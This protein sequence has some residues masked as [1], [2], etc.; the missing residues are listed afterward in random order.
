MPTP[1]QSELIGDHPSAPS[2]FAKWLKSNDLPVTATKSHRSLTPL[3]ATNDND[4][5]EWLGKKLFEH[6]HSDYRVKKL[7]ENYAKLGFKKYAERHGKLPKSDKTK[8]G[9]ATEILLTEYI[10]GCFNRKLIKVFK[11]KYNPNVDQAMKGDDTLMID[12]VKDGKKD[13]V[14][15]YLGEAKFRKTP[16][17]G[18]VKTIAKSLSKDKLPLSYSFLVDE[19]GR[20]SETEALADIL[21]AHIV[22]KIKGKG[23][24]IYTGFLLSNTDTFTVVESSLKSDNPQMVLISIGIDNP[25]ELIS[26]AFEKA[27]YFVLNPHTI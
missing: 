9:N 6:H 20:K 24:L 10:E 5:I 15:V 18:V 12:I 7:K 27:E 13:K 2:I 3:I 22:Q 21:D 8:K 11:L 23:D 1:K 17:K 4:L 26:K 25:E 16:T 19:L 14:K